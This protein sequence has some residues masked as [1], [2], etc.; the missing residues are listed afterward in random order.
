MSFQNPDD[1][2]IRT[3]LKKVKNIAVLGLSPK[4]DRPSY[5]VAKAMQGF[6][7]SIIPVRPAI[8]EVLGQKAYASLRDVTGSIDLVDVF[9][10]AEYLDAIVDDCIALQLPA[11]WIQEGIVN[12][13]AAERA[14]AAGMTVVMDRCIYKDYVALCS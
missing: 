6:G 8:A 11:I 14:R 13:A 10:A 3:L 4:P 1:E 9:R 12:E 2:S 7:F 5:F